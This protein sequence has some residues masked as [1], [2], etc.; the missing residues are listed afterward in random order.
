MTF[1]SCTVQEE[2]LTFH[3]INPATPPYISFAETGAHMIL[4]ATKTNSLRIPPCAV[5]KAHRTQALTSTPPG[6]AVAATP[7]SAN[8]SVRHRPPE[9]TSG[10]WLAL[11]RQPFLPF[12]GG[13]APPRCRCRSQPRAPRHSCRARRAARRLQDMSGCCQPARRVPRARRPIRQSGWAPGP[14]IPIPISGEPSPL[15]RE[16]GRQR[17]I[18][19]QCAGTQ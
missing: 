7:P 1:L 15:A 16:H 3:I 9:R 8:K 5:L 12:R 4:P 19:Q 2:P 10:L 6:D 14:G 17:S 13:G 11:V 18:K